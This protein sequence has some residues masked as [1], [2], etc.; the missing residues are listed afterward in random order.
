[1]SDHECVFCKHREKEAADDVE[2]HAIDTGEYICSNCLDDIRLFK[3]DTATL[4]FLSDEHVSDEAGE[5]IAERFENAVRE[6]KERFED[7]VISETT[8]S[9]R[10]TSNATKRKEGLGK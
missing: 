4:L 9:N 1:M 5:F 8:E 2:F 3:G 7:G 10:H 6:A